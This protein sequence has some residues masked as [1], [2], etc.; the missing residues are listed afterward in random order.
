MSEQESHFRDTLTT[1][2]AMEINRALK[3]DDADACSDIIAS[4]AEMLG[5]TIARVTDGDPSRT[6]EILTAT[7]ILVTEEAAGMA[8]LCE[9]KRWA[10]NRGRT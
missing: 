7:E 6:A 9:L 8:K 10:E 2:C 3:A 1:L 4:L 5:R